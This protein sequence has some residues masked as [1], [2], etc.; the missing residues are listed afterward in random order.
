MRAI[1]HPLQA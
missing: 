1:L